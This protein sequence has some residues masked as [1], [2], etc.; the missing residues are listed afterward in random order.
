MDSHYDLVP[1]P[2]DFWD[3]ARCLPSLEPVLY[4]ETRSWEVREAI[5]LIKRH[6]P[7]MWLAVT[8]GHHTG[9]A[10]AVRER[11]YIRMVAIADRTNRKLFACWVIV[12]AA[13]P[14]LTGIKR[15]RKPK[16]R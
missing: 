13:Q 10:D 14:A 2:Y 5:A 4:P 11:D 6:N 8:Q 16:Y 3:P 9:F 15:Q 12:M 1:G 7:Q